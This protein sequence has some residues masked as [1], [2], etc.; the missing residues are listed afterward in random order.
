MPAEGNGELWQALRYKCGELLALV[1]RADDPKEAAEHV[2][3]Y[4]PKYLDH[5]LGPHWARQ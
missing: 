1:V 2:L 4:L 5:L 3:D